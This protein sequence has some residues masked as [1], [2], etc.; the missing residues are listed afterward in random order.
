MGDIRPRHI[1]RNQNCIRIVWTD[2]RIEHGTAAS[3][4]DHHK[5]SRTFAVAAECKSKH[6]AEAKGLQQHLIV[7]LS[8]DNLLFVYPRIVDLLLMNALI[9]HG[10]GPTSVINASLAG[11]VEESRAHRT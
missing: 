2:G 3:R 10:G 5:M 1:A 4:A 8:F 9:A 11:L 7:C 6:D